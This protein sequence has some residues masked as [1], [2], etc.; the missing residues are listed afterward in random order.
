EVKVST[1]DFGA[2]QA[3]G[4]VVIAAVGKS[5]GSEYHGSMYAYMR[6]YQANC[7]DW[8]SKHFGVARPQAKYFYPGVNAGGPGMI[9]GT[10]FNHNKRLVFWAG[11]EYYGQNLPEALF[12]ALIP[13]QRMLGGDLS[14]DSLATALNV[15]GGGPSLSDKTTGCTGA[16]QTGPKYS[17]IGSL[18]Y[19]M[20]GG[21]DMNGNNIGGTQAAP[22]NP[23]VISPQAIDPGV[24]AYAKWY[25]K[26]NR[27]PQP[28]AGT[29]EVT[30]TINY[31]ENQT[32][33]QNGFQFH[34]RI[35]ENISDSL[36]LYATYNWEKIDYIGHTGPA[37]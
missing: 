33:T 21:T 7:D 5:G 28:V 3:R 37:Y 31:A 16:D 6:N 11:Y 9:P 34:S 26:P 19:S 35:D 10:H 32:K 4:P 18:C 14:P 13:S 1:S 36:K 22:L 17:N 29:T 25:P 15:P 30:D 20:V 12:T 23:G 8:I 2:D 24:A 27:I